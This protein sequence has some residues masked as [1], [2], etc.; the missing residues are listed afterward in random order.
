MLAAAIQDGDQPNISVAV[1]LYAL[2]AGLMC[3]SWLV[4]FSYLGR[5]PDLLS[6]VDAAFFV[7]ERLRA[8]AGIIGY[9]VAGGLGFVAPVALP[10]IVLL[11]L[12]VFYFITSQGLS[13]WKD[14]GVV[15]RDSSPLT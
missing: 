13:G 1:A 9:A 4:M 10:L 5:H 11:A 12:P 15:A 14:R 2:V 8:W 6:G 3:A 7:R